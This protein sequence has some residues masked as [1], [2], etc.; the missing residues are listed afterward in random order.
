MMHKCVACQSDGVKL[1][2]ITLRPHFIL[3]RQI[4]HL[5]LR[6]G[7]HNVAFHFEKTRS[8]IPIYMRMAFTAIRSSQIMFLLAKRTTC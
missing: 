8:V 6:V 1:L 2:Y 5:R 4:C 3:P 7:R